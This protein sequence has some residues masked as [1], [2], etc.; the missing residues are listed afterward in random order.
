MPENEPSVADV[1]YVH[2]LDLCCGLGL[3]LA[4]K[5]LGLH[6]AGAWEVSRGSGRRAGKEG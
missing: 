2:V 6:Q 3:Q 5:E 4:L 1:P